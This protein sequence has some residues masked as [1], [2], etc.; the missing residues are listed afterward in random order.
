MAPSVEEQAE[1]KKKL[2][3]TFR[4]EVIALFA[5]ITRDFFR[6]AGAT[7]QPQDMERYLPAWQSLL[8]AHYSRVQSKFTGVV[9]LEPPPE[10]QEEAAL[11]LSLALI[12]YRDDNALRQATY[13]TQTNE[14]N[15]NEALNLGRQTL[16]DDDQ[17]LTPIAV[18]AAATAVLKRK[19]AGRVGD[20][21]ISETQAPAENTKFTEAEV[22]TG[23]KPSILSGVVLAVLWKT[24]RTAGDKLVRD[25]HKKV[26]GQRVKMSEPFV[27]N[28]ESLMY[29][30][31]SSRGASA[32]NI[33]NCRCGAEYSAT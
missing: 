28:G 33:I 32:G 8:D 13:I 16:L 12:K 3:T 30:G 22:S 31:D 17:D 27:V 5:L 19:F 29:P 7:G 23:K 26:N 2:E 9:G 14:K 21:T 24:W 18:A 20:I 25:L 1:D 10:L 6:T 11:A 15:A 4:P